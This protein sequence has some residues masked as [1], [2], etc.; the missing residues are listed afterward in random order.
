MSYFLSGEILLPGKELLI[1]GDEAKHLLASRRIKVGEKI[2]LQSP[3]LNRYL[4]QVIS[5][6][7]QNVKVK[8]LNKIETPQESH[9]NITIFQSLIKEKALD[10][11]IQKTTELGVRKLI[12]FPTQNS[13]IDIQKT[14]KKLERW[15]KIADEAAKQSDR[16][17]STQISFLK[18]LEEV[19][20]HSENMD[21]TFL[22]EKTAKK[23]FAN[24]DLKSEKLSAIGIVIGPEGGLTPKEINDISFWPKTLQVKLGPRV[25]RADTAAI[26][27]TA[28]VQHIWGDI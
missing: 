6:D 27:A 2:S 1:E 13:P 17:T 16:I 23:R 21:K 24:I 3:N 12:I 15:K 10:F 5:I 14:E 18:N 19:R 11:I 25:L 22:L 8:I 7:K 9:L 26:S 20:R 4:A 28:I